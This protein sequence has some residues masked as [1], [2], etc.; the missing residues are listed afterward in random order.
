MSAIQNITPADVAALAVRCYKDR[1]FDVLGFT[2]KQ[3]DA[4]KTLVIDTVVEE[5]VYGG[6]AGG[7]K[8]FLGVSWLFLSCLAYPGTNW[9]IGRYKKSQI[10]E[11]IV[12]TTIPKVCRKFGIERKLF[13]INTI[14]G[15]VKF[16][17]GSNINFL[18]LAYK[19]GEDR[20]YDRLG[21]TE[22]TGGW[23]EEGGQVPVLAYEVIKQRIGRQLNDEYGI[24]GKLLITCNPTKN[25]IYSQF[26]KQWR[27][28]ALEEHK[29]FIQSL[30]DENTYIETGYVD[31]LNKLTGQ[32]YERKRKG[33]W[34][35]TGGP[36]DLVQYDAII[37][38]FDNIHVEA[39]GEKY[40]TV[41][42]AM[43]GSDLF[44]AV[45]WHGFVAI[46]HTSV[47]KTGG[48]QILEVVQDMRTRHG[49][50]ARNIA[51]DADG[52]GA[53]LGGT[54]GFIPGAMPFHNGGAPLKEKETRG[55]KPPNYENL[56]T[57]C[58]YNLAKRINN[59]GYY[60]K[61]IESK[62][63]QDMLIEEL[64]Q[65]KRRDADKDGKLKI[66]RK[67]DVRQAIGR[68]PDFSDVVMIRE[69]F[70]LDYRRLPQMI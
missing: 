16:G 40:L 36:E 2:E 33:N 1:S 45:V 42:I 22:Y 13:R 69:V 52:V 66:V 26:Y 3:Q 31:R 70:E 11:S 68:S 8:S 58:S 29:A 39:R 10:F 51:Y 57:Q 7:G 23:I 14:K 62:E 25:W 34:E 37:D 15:F 60:F 65:I 32:E 50:P 43:Q 12:E 55:K 5:L 44:R 48:R 35:Y 9:F 38:S 67:E 54:G 61:A 6:A 27:E 64:E 21:S 46:E 63:D 53:F 30:V 56:K 41:D 20:E 59:N 49:I 18:E 17:N 47:P 4:L 24:P 28:S 19:P